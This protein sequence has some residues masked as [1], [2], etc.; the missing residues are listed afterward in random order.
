MRDVDLFQMALAVC[1]PWFVRD[2]DFCAEEKR[3]DIH[4][5][6]A[7]GAEFACP[8]CGQGGRK[9]YDTEILTWRHLNFFQHQCYLH[10]RTPRV[11]CAQCGIKSVSVPWG[12]SGSGFT[13]LFEAFLPALAREMPV[14]AIA[15]MVGEHDT[16]LW[17]VLRHYVDEAR[18]CADHSHVKRVGVDETSKGKHHDY[19][20]V[21][22]DLDE[23]QVL[24]VTPGKDAATVDEF[25][26]DLVEHG[27]GPEQIR[28]VCCDLSPAFISGV[29]TAF[30]QAELTFDR[31]HLTKLVNEAVDQVRREEA[32][33]R[34]E[35]L[36]TRYHWLKNPANL[37]PWQVADLAR[38][39]MK[40][41]HLKTA[42]A[43]QLRL[44]FQE[45][46]TLAPAQAEPFLR[47]W[48]FWAT[49]SRLSPMIA[50]ARTIKRHW[51]GVLRWFHSRISNGLLEGLNS[52]IQAAKAKARGYRS[53]RNMATMIYLIAGKLKFNLPI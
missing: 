24:F 48:Y 12:R 51:D 28:E 32:K 6:F 44:A 21:F 45:L 20:T 53:Q 40:S 37:K 22:A 35:L 7:R 2:S 27:G 16:R 25:R 1:P 36:K 46:F 14:S 42:R 8:D 31:F 38:L 30:E 4:I 50:A 26:Q 23:G 39:T 10:V 11:D 34:P 47:K 19:V 29:Q 17:R 3:L 15:R 43:Y 5:D 52:L 13:L 49:H 33:E 41:L 9:A 18:E